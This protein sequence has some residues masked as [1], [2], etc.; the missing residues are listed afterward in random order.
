MAA[1]NNEGEKEHDMTPD[2][3]KI[4]TLLEEVFREDLDLEAAC[5]PEC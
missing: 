1:G 5:N 4:T 3:V 2:H